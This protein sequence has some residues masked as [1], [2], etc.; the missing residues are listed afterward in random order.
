[1]RVR[2]VRV[3]GF[4]S[5]ASL[6]VELAE[7]TA[8]FGEN[9]AGVGLLLDALTR[10]L[11]VE[12]EEDGALCAFS[13]ADLPHL[14][15]GERGEILVLL[16]LEPSRE[17][18]WSEELHAP[19][20]TELLGEQPGRELVRLAIRVRV[21]G[22]Q[23]V[24]QSETYESASGRRSEHPALRAW[25][26]T[27]LPLL[28]LSRGLFSTPAAPRERRAR[29]S[30]E[31]PERGALRLGF[32]RWIAAQ[33]TLDDESW[34][35]I[36]P[37]I[38]HL[39]HE[40]QRHLV[41]L[42][43]TSG[44][45]ASDF[46][47][48]VPRAAQRT[49]EVPLESSR[50]ARLALLLL[51]GALAQRSSEPLHPQS[52]PF[53]V[54]GDLEAQ[55]HSTTR[56]ALLGFLLHLRA[57]VVFSTHSSQVLVHLPLSALRRV[58]RVGEGARSFGVQ[59]R[60]IPRDALRKIR[61]HLVTRHPEALLARAWLLVEGET[62]AWLLPEIARAA[63]YYLPIEGVVLIE[64]AQCGL[65]PLLRL[66]E[67]LRIEW[68]VLSDGDAAGESYAALA[69]KHARGASRD[70]RVT[71]LPERD[72]ETSFW[73]HGFASVIQ[74]LAGTIERRARESEPAFAHRAI[75]KALDRH[76]KPQVALKLIEALGGARAPQVPPPLARCIEA[77]IE[78]A[79][80]RP[81]LAAD[82]APRARRR[83]TPR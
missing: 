20:R 36:Y 38:E 10:A 60:A 8:L 83:A 15:S 80:K 24:E 46:D 32:T 62:E 72:I 6:E 34:E 7:S 49:R 75:K 55:L 53:L 50:G 61:Y 17:G 40:L 19:L 39:W 18:E 1:M 33:P 57:Q 48:D 13:L 81:L 44:W 11:R 41:P 25:R 77:T 52:S 4:R 63:G 82:A 31:K 70:L 66:A 56:F 47:L 78:L 79:R 3:E 67:S 65:A 29:T 64:Y 45:L 30:T 5:L 74:R 59:P 51:A 22:Q 14:V 12:D 37:D 68:H 16:E 73:R 43:T 54:L 9:D 42:T 28:D 35:R 23:G 69:R 21:S 2:R 27:A 71:E 76:A 58:V 26:R